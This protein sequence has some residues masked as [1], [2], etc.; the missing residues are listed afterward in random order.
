M[1]DPTL[2]VY[3]AMVAA[4]VQKARDEEQKREDDRKERDAFWAKFHDDMDRTFERG[5]YRKR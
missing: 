2:I 5:R 4:G 1:M 3:A